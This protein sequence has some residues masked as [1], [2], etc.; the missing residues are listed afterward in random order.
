MVSTKRL[1]PDLFLRSLNNYGELAFGAF[2]SV[3]FDSF[4]FVRV[5]NAIHFALFPLRQQC[6]GGL[7]VICK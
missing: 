2:D 3:E 4:D 6:I 7:L 5:G 1:L